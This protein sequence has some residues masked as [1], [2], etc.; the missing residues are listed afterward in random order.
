MISVSVFLNVCRQAELSHLQP[1]GGDTHT[2]DLVHDRADDGTRVTI[3]GSLSEL[4]KISGAIEEYLSQQSV[5]CPNC[6]GTGITD[7]ATGIIG[8]ASYWEAEQRIEQAQCE[9]CGGSGTI[10][11][12]HSQEIARERAESARVEEHFA[13]GG[14]VEE[15]PF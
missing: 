7:V 6:G 10:T 12:D 9:T 1:P 8:G 5:P 11:W 4:A 13:R 2:L 3:F 15:L 14:T